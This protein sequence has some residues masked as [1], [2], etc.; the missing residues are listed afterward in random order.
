VHIQQW[1]ILKSQAPN[2][3]AQ[4]MV[5][6]YIIATFKSADFLSC[7]YDHLSALVAVLLVS[8]FNRG[9]EMRSPF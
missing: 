7:I 8:R 4:E 3:K 2:D 6:I 9:T 5:E 1:H